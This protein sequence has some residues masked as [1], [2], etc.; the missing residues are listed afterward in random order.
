MLVDSSGGVV[1]TFDDC[2]LL[3]FFFYR[4]MGDLDRVENYT[5]G[6]DLL[7]LPSDINSQTEETPFQKTDTRKS[8]NDRRV[9]FQ[10]ELE[11]CYIRSTRCPVP[12][13]QNQVTHLT[14]DPQHNTTQ[15]RTERRTLLCAFNWRLRETKQLHLLLIL[16]PIIKSRTLMHK[17]W[18][19]TCHKRSLGAVSLTLTSF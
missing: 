15:H 7:I 11:T 4:N 10:S 6:L 16:F 14:P 17:T 5:E 8:L 1:D 12:S 9:V 13:S 2:S 19:T 3:F 18:G